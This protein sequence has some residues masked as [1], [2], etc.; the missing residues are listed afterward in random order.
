MRMLCSSEVGCE[1]LAWGVV[2][3]GGGGCWEREIRVC[4][5]DKDIVSYVDHLESRGRMRLV[6]VTV[7]LTHL[8]RNTD[9][10]LPT[11]HYRQDCYV[12]FLPKYKVVRKECSDKGTRSPLHYNTW[13]TLCH[14]TS[15]TR[16]W[17]LVAHYAARD[18]ASNPP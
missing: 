6:V 13:R 17:V 8:Q 11:S 4:R 3:G 9:L 15:N 12:G 2:G 5:G 7:I 18:H 10:R 14:H 16:K 1:V